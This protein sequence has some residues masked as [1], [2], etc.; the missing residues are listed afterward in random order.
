MK[1]EY[2]LKLQAK[3]R[4]EDIEL[5]NK[6]CDYVADIMTLALNREGFGKERIK[7]VNRYFN[8]LNDEYMEALQSG[9]DY[10]NEKLKAAVRDVM[11]GEY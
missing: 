7:R 9:S 1:N 5:I 3:R 11:G 2:I 8:E 4:A 6:T 10:A